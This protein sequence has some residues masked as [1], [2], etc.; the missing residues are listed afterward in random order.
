MLANPALPAG[1]IDR[2]AYV[3]CVLEQLH[4]ALVR[5]DVYAAPLNRWSDPRARLLDGAGWDAVRQDVLAGLSLDTP[6]IEHLA[7]LTG[8]LDA[9][10]RQMAARMDEAG[11]EAKVEVVIPPE[12]GRAR[13]SVDKLGALDE[14]DSLTGCERQQRRCCP[15]STCRTCCSRCT[16]GPVSS[17][18]SP[19]FPRAPAAWPGSISAW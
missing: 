19:T 13:L 18:G 4:R 1:A 7:E 5:R 11:P 3:V 2:D 8:G 6:V 15:G 12:G 14:P 17:T 9:A 16:P 10:W